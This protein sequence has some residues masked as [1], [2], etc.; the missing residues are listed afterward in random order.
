[1]HIDLSKVLWSTREYSRA[2]ECRSQRAAWGALVAR[3]NRY[4]S[5]SVTIC[6]YLYMYMHAHMRCISG[7]IYIYRGRERQVSDSVSSVEKQGEA[8]A[9]AVE[10]LPQP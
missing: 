8:K 4:E 1:M 2:P 5:D 3:S 10:V 6:K 7:A 9:R